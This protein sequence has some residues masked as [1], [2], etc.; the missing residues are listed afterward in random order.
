MRCCAQCFISWLQGREVG[1]P[2]RIYFTQPPLLFLVTLSELCKS[3]DAGD[4]VAFLAGG[5]ISEFQRGVSASLSE[6]HPDVCRGGLRAEGDHVPRPGTALEDCGLTYGSWFYLWVCYLT[7][8]V[9]SSRSR[10]SCSTCTWFSLTQW[11]WRNTKKILRC[12]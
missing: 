12:W 8:V 7:R 2:N 9:L 5:N 6:D 4:H 1:R 3:E 11:R 10:I